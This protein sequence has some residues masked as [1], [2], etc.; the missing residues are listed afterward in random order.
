MYSTQIADGYWVHNLEH[1]GIV[2]LY[3]CEAGCDSTVA[4]IKAI[5]ARLPRSKWG[6]VKF[7]A[8]QYTEMDAPFT[9]VAWNRQQAL[10]RL[11][12]EAIRSF[13]RQFVD[14]GPE[15]SR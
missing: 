11:D 6:N 3:K 1:G 8:T 13:Y 10:T 15:D 12:E 5:D 14:Q 2:L 4:E 9:L 7:L